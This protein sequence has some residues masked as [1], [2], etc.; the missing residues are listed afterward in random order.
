MRYIYP[1]AIGAY[2]WNMLQRIREAVGVYPTQT[3]DFDGPDGK[4]TMIQ[5]D[6]ALTAA[7]KTALDNLMLANPAN[8]PTPAGTVFKL[9]DIW[10][11]LAEFNA[12]TGITFRLYYS[13]S[14]PGSGKI[15]TIELHAN[16]VLTN[17][18]KTRVKNTFA[19]ILKEA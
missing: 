13:E 19:A 10:E 1:H 9:D 16:S 15:D 5:F 3:G 14:V 12:A 6:A 2:R 4:V 11:K 17:T 8:P 18:Q 7:Q